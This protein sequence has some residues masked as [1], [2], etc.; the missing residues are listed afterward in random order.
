MPRHGYPLQQPSH[1]HRHQGSLHADCWWV[2][3]VLLSTVFKT[4]TI[5]HP[6]TP[7][8]CSL[9]RAAATV[10]DERRTALDDFW[11][12]CKG[13]STLFHYPCFDLCTLTRISLDRFSL[14]YH[15]AN[16]LRLIP[17]TVHVYY[18]KTKKC[19]WF[20][21][22]PTN[23]DI[24]FSVEVHSKVC[25]F[26]LFSFALT[27]Y[28]FNNVTCF[29]SCTL[30]ILSNMALYL[31]LMPRRPTMPT[32]TWPRLTE[33]TSPTRSLPLPVRTAYIKNVIWIG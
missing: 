31:L 28:P 17:V 16:R 8:R 24:P 3:L 10:E 30:L 2:C 19:S 13:T 1:H 26:P 5:P 18:L 20:P 22:R 12:T 29:E 7:Y 27:M 25:Y 33:S 4:S 9:R 32:S 23:S 15:L 21:L 6:S 14:G 11:K